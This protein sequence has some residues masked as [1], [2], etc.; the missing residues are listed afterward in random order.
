MK[1]KLVFL[2]KLLA[3][4]KKPRGADV[5]VTVGV[6]LFSCLIIMPSIVT[7]IRNNSRARCEKHMY[8]MLHVINDAFKYE[9]E[10]GGTYW[11]DLIA[12]GNY[13]KFLSNIN[14]KTP[15]GRQYPASDYYIRTGDNKIT[16]V[17][18]KHKD[19]LE[20]SV[21][22]SVKG[23]TD[24]EVTE[25]PMFTDKILYI[26]ADGPDTYYK[27]DSLDDV[28]PDKMVFY[29]GEIDD[30]LQNIKASAVYIGGYKQELSRGDYTV[31]A[32]KLD[33]TKAG[34]K[35]LIVKSTSTSLWDNSAYT[36]FDINVTDEKDAIPLIVDCGLDG[37]YE[38]AQWDWEDYLTEASAMSEGEIFGASIIRYK[39]N[40]YYYPDGMRIINGEKNTSPMEYAFDTEN[41]NKPAYYIKFNPESVI[42]NSSDESKINDGSIKAE[43]GLIYIYQSQ[44]SKELPVGWIRVYCDLKKY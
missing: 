3:K 26:T 41:K 33:M 39:G 35:H 34:M 28:Y 27:G 22:F 29:N 10:S 2:E 44:P 23:Y 17:C 21:D 7:C 19:I 1:N 20:K 38:L 6:V 25:K 18:K 11:H 12:N 16:I 9:A 43:N 15:D 31:T 14:N 4:I 37:R 32:K 24:V 8:Y 40:F 5:L 13:Q 42:L 36:T 30:V